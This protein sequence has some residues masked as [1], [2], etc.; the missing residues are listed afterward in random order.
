MT[1]F[2]RIHDK[3]P[4]IAAMEYEKY[5]HLLLHEVFKERET[6]QRIQM[7]LPQHLVISICFRFQVISL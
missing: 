3:S 2:T 1:T 4:E 7:S 5:L 6:L